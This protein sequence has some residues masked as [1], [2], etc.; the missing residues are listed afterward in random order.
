MKQSSAISAYFLGYT[1][2][3]NFGR[4]ACSNTQFVDPAGMAGAAPGGTSPVITDEITGLKKVLL[5]SS[6]VSPACQPLHA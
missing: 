4:R 3:T 6:S 5:K 2:F 1:D